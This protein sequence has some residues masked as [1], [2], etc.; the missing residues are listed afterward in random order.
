MQLL[1]ERG[2]VIL[3]H[4]HRTLLRRLVPSLALATLLL[5]PLQTEASAYVKFQGI[6]GGATAASH[7][8]WTD[9]IAVEW[10]I[11]NTGKKNKAKAIEV[12]N[13]KITT[14]IDDASPSIHLAALNANT[15]SQVLF[16]ATEGSSQRVYYSYELRSAKVVGYDIGIWQEGDIDEDLVAT[17][18]LE[19]SQVDVSYTSPGGEVSSFTWT[20]K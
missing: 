14:K 11:T 2:T 5:L 7:T 13:M 1:G 15:F 20:V 3:L 12:G 18:E 6:E 16:E 9:V 4:L 10:S 17:I 19:F 8:G